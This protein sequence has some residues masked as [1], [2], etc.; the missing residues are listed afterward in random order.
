MAECVFEVLFGIVL[1][2]IGIPEN[3][4][5]FQENIHDAVLSKMKLRHLITLKRELH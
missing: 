3:F 1:Q 5:N 4:T 2:S